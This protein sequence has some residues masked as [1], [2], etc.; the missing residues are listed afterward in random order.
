LRQFIIICLIAGMF[1][2]PYGCAS[3]S[4]GNWSNE[5]AGWKTPPK[6]P[7]KNDPKIQPGDTL[8][9]SIWEH[10][11]LGRER[12]VSPEGMLRLPLLGEL[13]VT[14]LTVAELEK[15]LTKAMAPYIKNPV[16]SVEHKAKSASQQ[17]IVLGAINKPG[18]Y[19][20][21]QDQEV[22]LLTLL[23]AAGGYTN[24]ANLDQAY[25]FRDNSPDQKERLGTKIDLRSILNDPASRDIT[26]RNNDVVILEGSSGSEW[27]TSVSTVM[28]T[29]QLIA[30]VLGI[31]WVST[32]IQD[33]K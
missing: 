7:P 15:T 1:L 22:K 14:G 11:E 2:S 18:N 10:P 31:F 8:I 17:I 33:R 5:T 25:L 6:L 12:I 21:P 9:V 32:N 20:F 27:N 3:S 30:V 26:L 13:R 29:L 16:I 4:R 23:G 19:E 28:P 24:A